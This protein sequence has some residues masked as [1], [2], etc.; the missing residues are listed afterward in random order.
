LV[1]AWFFT[2]SNKNLSYSGIL[3]ASMAF[4]SFQALQSRRY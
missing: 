4:E 1:A 3:F 2:Q